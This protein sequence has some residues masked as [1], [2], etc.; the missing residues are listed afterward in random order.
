M[1]TVV[2]AHDVPFLPGFTDLVNDERV[3]N[4]DDDER[5]EGIYASVQIGPY[6]INQFRVLF[7]RLALTR[8]VAEA[9]FDSVIESLEFCSLIVYLFNV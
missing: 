7:C 2:V 1:T 6:F 8:H 4:D 9:H 3:K 5:Y